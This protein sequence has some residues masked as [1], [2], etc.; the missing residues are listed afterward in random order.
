MKLLRIL[1]WDFLRVLCGSG[2]RRFLRWH[3]GTTE[4]AEAGIWLVLSLAIRTLHLLSPLWH[5]FC[6]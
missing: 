5:L 1:R 6:P 3:R 2:G 4:D